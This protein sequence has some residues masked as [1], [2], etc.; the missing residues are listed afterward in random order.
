MQF[1]KMNGSK[2][3]STDPTP[4]DPTRPPTNPTS[5]PSVPTVPPRSPPYAP[6]VGKSINSLAAGVGNV[7]F[8]LSVIFAVGWLFVW[9]DFIMMGIAGYGSVLGTVFLLAVPT[10]IV[11]IFWLLR[12]ILT[13]R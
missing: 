1:V 6:T 12:D 13:G 5:R 9:F 3:M 4:P 2:P 10:V 8:L 7:L 11:G